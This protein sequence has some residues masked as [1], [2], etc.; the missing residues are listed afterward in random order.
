[1]QTITSN[2]RKTILDMANKSGSPHVG[3]ALSCVDIISTLY[4]KV[5]NITKPIQ[6]DRDYFLLSKATVT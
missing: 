1:M 6:N 4:Y 2:I 3:S 5:M